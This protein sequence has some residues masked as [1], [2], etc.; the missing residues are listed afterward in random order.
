VTGS[1]G[2][3]EASEYSDLDLFFVHTGQSKR[4]GISRVEK[5]LLDAG[6]IKIARKLNFPEFS[7][8][9]EYLEIHYL[10][11]MLNALGGPDDDYQN[12]FTARMLLLLESL[13]LRSEGIYNTIIDEIVNAYFRDYHDH[14]KD[15]LPIFFVND[16]HR[17]W[18]TLCLNYEHAR[19]RANEKSP[20]EKNKAHLKNLKLKFSRLLTCYSMIASIL[21]EVGA[22][23]PRSISRIIHEIPVER[24]ASVATSNPH[25]GDLVR[26]VLDEYSWF[27][28]SMDHSE[29]KVLEWIGER[30]SRNIAFER[31]RN[32]GK[33]MHELILEITNGT[34]KLRYLVV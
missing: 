10:E 28:E 7:K 33:S 32:F 25:L 2:R 12:Y 24:V 14:D 23:N 31:A 20:L 19:N 13:P 22:V 26:K 5:A 3:L 18:R 11:D 30:E 34:D 29:Q 27:M 15:F 8:G 4:D 6:V 16:V 21:V 1:Y 9:G 17:F